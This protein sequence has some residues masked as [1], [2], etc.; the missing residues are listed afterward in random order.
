MKKAKSRP[1]LVTVADA[2]K[3]GFCI[4]GLRAWAE[5]EGLDFRDLWWN[6][7][8]VKELEAMNDAYANQILAHKR[9]AEKN[10]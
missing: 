2:V 1:D 8:P 3:A 6:G 4:K 5:N 9:K 10:G 7:M